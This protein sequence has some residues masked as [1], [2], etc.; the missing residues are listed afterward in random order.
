MNVIEISVMNTLPRMTDSG[1][2]IVPALTYPPNDGFMAFAKELTLIVILASCG[3]VWV[4]VLTH[5]CEYITR[6]VNTIS[7]GQICELYKVNV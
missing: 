3:A 7:I 6:V 1:G 5:A 2:K 4:Q